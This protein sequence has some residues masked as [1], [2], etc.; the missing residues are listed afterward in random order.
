MEAKPSGISQASAASSHSIKAMMDK[1]TQFQVK[2][3]V[4]SKISPLFH[5]YIPKV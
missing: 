2:D 3:I 5:T 4:Y 1:L